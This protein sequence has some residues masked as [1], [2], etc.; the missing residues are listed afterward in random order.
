MAETLHDAL[1]LLRDI[2]SV[3][4][5]MDAADRGYGPESR[6]RSNLHIHLPPNFSAFDSIAQAVDLAADQDVRVLCASNYYDFG[7]YADFVSFCRSKHIFPTFGT[8][9]ICLIENLVQQGVLINDPGN[10]GKMYYCGKGIAQLSSLRARAEEILEGIRL[11]D[12]RRMVEMIAKVESIFADHA[13]P[14]QLTEDRIRQAVADRHGCGIGQVVLQERHIAQAFQ[15]AMFRTVPTGQRVEALGKLFG[16]RDYTVDPADAVA[17]QGDIRKHLMKAGKPAFVPDTFGGLGEARQ[18]VL[19]LGGI[20]CYPTLADG[21]SPICPYEDPVE[22][23]IERLAGVDVYCAEFIPVRNDPETLKH[24]V[25]AMRQ[26]GLVV[27][28]G[29][30]HNTLDLL[31]IE[32]RCV[33]GVEIDDDLKDIFWEGAC[34][35]AAHQF[36]TLHGQ[37]GYV[38]DRGELNPDYEDAEERIRSLALLGSAVIQTWLDAC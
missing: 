14:T 37:C 30:E 11:R 4:E 8:E 20:P 12:G 21:A 24:Y 2:G 3:E 32:P 18:L 29:T 28:A 22:S 7:V 27:L 36:L 6:L 38:D 23:L 13:L 33:G 25:T 1:E 31:P 16:L 26:A 19:E 17:V 9:T 35:V 5:L 34:V 10:P 15:E